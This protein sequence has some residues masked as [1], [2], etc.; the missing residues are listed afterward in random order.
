MRVESLLFKVLPENPLYCLLLPKRSIELW[1]VHYGSRVQELRLAKVVRKLAERSPIDEISRAINPEGSAQSTDER[2]TETLREHP[3]QRR[4]CAQQRTIRES[5][6]D[7]FASVHR[8]TQGI[9]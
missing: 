2:E 8:N 3:I 6:C 5:G 9:L 7:N 1:R 4:C